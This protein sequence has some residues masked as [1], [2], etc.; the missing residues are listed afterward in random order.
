M[1]TCEQPG[2]ITFLLR[3]WRQ[4][5]PGAQ[6][7]LFELVFC[8]L[9]K[10]AHNLLAKERQGHPMDSRDLV[11]EAYLRLLPAKDRM[12]WQNR[13]HFYAISARAM[14]WI[15]IDIGR[16]RARGPEVPLPSDDFA[17]YWPNLDETIAVAQCMEDLEKVNPQWCRVVEYKVLLRLT[18][19]ET[20][21]AMN[22]GLHTTQ[23]RW[24]E[25]RKWL[26]KRMKGK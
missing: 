26:F 13:Q 6:D 3:Q 7:K 23:R 10:I 24:H 25:A 9:R 20:A 2:D 8:H 21:E 16:K 14:R 5:I 17:P 22:L 19:E 4:G 18:D 12:D 15:L 1:A 11:A